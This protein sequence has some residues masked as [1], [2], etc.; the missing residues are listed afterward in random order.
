MLVISRRLNES[1][2]FPNLGI[3]V[4]LLKN[5]GS[6]IRL[7]I[8]AP[9]DVDILRD[10]LCA[11][12][13]G[14]KYLLPGVARERSP[15]NTQFEAAS[16]IIRKLRVT[17]EKMDWRES[18]ALISAAFSELRSLDVQIAEAESGRESVDY[19]QKR[20]LLVDDNRNESRLLASYLR[21]RKFDVDVAFDGADA[22]AQL[23]EKPSPDVVL[24]DMNMPRFDGRW[25]IN[26]MRSHPLHHD[27]KIFAVSGMDPEE[28]DVPVGRPGVDRWLR[29]PLNPEEL[30][31][32]IVGAT[33][34]EPSLSA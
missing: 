7:G 19:P 6:R 13:N 25:A 12:G 24:L 17:L 1:V 29:K 4:T 11:E 22:I 32:E 9:P 3:T 18:R 30:V 27:L 5:T 2:R 16:I 15:M 23:D 21:L 33:H 26:E 28:C 34:D 14:A 8:D 20:A 31:R 10:E